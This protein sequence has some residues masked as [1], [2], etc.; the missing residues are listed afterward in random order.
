MDKAWR[1]SLTRACE[2]KEKKPV[3]LSVFS[4]VPDLLFDCPRVLEYEKIRSVL[5]SKVIPL[6]I[7]KAVAT[8]LICSQCLNSGGTREARSDVSL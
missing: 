5:Q 1:K 4:L 7:K 3:S 2:A 6:V 8:F